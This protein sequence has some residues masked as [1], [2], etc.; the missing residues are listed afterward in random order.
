MEIKV[1]KL[2]ACIK[3]KFYCFEDFTELQALFYVIK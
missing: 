3:E 2:S 1:W